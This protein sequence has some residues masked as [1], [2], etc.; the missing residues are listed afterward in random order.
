MSALPARA[1]GD[2]AEPALEEG[3]VA[4]ALNTAAKLLGF[5]P[6]EIFSFRANVAL[7]TRMRNDFVR[8][9]SETS[10]AAAVLAALETQ[11]P[12]AS[13]SEITHAR[14]TATEAA[15]AM[16]MIRLRI[17]VLEAANELCSITA[18]KEQLELLARV[19]GEYAAWVSASP[20]EAAAMERIRADKLTFATPE[21]N[22][23]HG[24]GILR[25]GRVILEVRRNRRG[26]P[27]IDRGGRP[28]LELLASTG[29]APHI[30][31]SMTSKRVFGTLSPYDTHMG[32]YGN[33]VSAEELKTAEP[34]AEWPRFAKRTL[35]DGAQFVMV[36]TPTAYHPDY[37]LSSV[38]VP[39]M[40]EAFFVQDMEETL[41][42][43]AGVA[44]AGALQP[45]GVVQ[46]QVLQALDAVIQ[47]A[48]ASEQAERA[49]LDEK[50]AQIRRDTAAMH[51]VIDRM[52]TQEEKEECKDEYQRLKSAIAAAGDAVDAE[53]KAIH[54]TP[55]QDRIRLRLM[56]AIVEHANAWSSG[57][58]S[59]RH[60][61]SA[62]FYMQNHPVAD[63]PLRVKCNCLVPFSTELMEII[64][65]QRALQ[66]A[67]GV[68]CSHI[69]TFPTGI[70][71][72]P[73]G[74]YKRAWNM[75]TAAELSQ[76][77]AEREAAAATTALVVHTGGGSGGV[78]GSGGGGSSSGPSAVAEGGAAPAWQPHDPKKMPSMPGFPFFRDGNVRPSRDPMEALLFAGGQMFPRRRPVKT[79]LGAHAAHIGVDA[80]FEDVLVKRLRNGVT[81]SET[82]PRITGG[83]FVE[84]TL[85]RTAFYSVGIYFGPTYKIS[86]G[87]I[88]GNV[89]DDFRTRAPE[90]SVLTIEGGDTEPARIMCEEQL[91]SLPPLAA[92]YF[93]EAAARAEAARAASVARMNTIVQARA[94]TQAAVARDRR[95]LPAP[96]GSVTDQFHAL[97]AG[98]VAAPPDLPSPLS[99]AAG[100]QARAVHAAHR[101][102]FGATSAAL[103]TGATV[104]MRMLSQ[105][106][107]GAES[108]SGGDDEAGGTMPSPHS[109]SSGAGSISGDQESDTARERTAF[110]HETRVVHA[111]HAEVA[112]GAVPDMRVAASKRA[113]AALASEVGSFTPAPKA[114]RPATGARQR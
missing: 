63:T 4:Y 16:N 58:V 73:L 111:T 84:F 66:K 53:Q 98:T 22:A 99:A 6:F 62:N 87:V 56:A 92:A 5:V 79:G 28:M 106:D 40:R 52:D 70:L 11:K 32:H 86:D 8:A 35:D 83:T 78:S 93:R 64:R 55:L 14:K 109:G 77:A 51:E 76:E 37:F 42:R 57:F 103:P 59:M 113:R 88:H 71:Y 112:Q 67:Q 47:D 65:T 101:A 19:E 25:G 102:S 97:M 30:F 81:L 26:Q 29:A 45:K 100:A 1:G 33:V 96:P 17:V 75:P 23:T 18:S 108:G 3:Q 89:V 50:R 31:F 2:A 46:L 27:L 9:T 90:S 110:P 72:D 41:I 61:K 94:L 107:V 85:S 104:E 20:L 38:I 69:N 36:V 60:A 95:A 82:M 39:E 43:R 105:E 80:P 21:E 15:D 48:T 91:L 24:L 12:P 74:M 13:V 68:S 34:G 7:L 10:A 114:R 49:S 44:F 54:D